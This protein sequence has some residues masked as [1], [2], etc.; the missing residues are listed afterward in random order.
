MKSDCIDH[1]RQSNVGYARSGS[2]YAM[3]KPALAHRKVFLEVY[4]Y[5]P[6][7]VMHSCDNPRCVNPEHLVAGDWG[8]NNRDRAAKGRSAKVVLTRRKVTDA[9]ADAIRARWEL[10]CRIG[11]H[12]KDPINGVC[13]LAR[14]FSVDT[15]VIYNIVKGKT[16]VKI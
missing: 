11:K 15:N 6:P 9:Q 1:G 13:A 5:L 10:R 7:V 4:G 14:E 2:A 12:K 3:D 16:H 8:L